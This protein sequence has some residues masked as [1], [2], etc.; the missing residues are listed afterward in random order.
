MINYEQQKDQYCDTNI[1]AF[2]KM[3]KVNF[4]NNIA[5]LTH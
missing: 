2:H 5:I 3:Y 1:Y 4:F